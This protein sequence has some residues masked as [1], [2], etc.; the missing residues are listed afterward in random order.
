[1]SSSA[2]YRTYTASR[3]RLPWRSPA[4]ET[5]T[6]SW[7]TDSRRSAP[8]SPAAGS[9]RQ[10]TAEIYYALVIRRTVLHDLSVLAIHRT[11]QINSRPTDMLTYLTTYPPHSL[12]LSL[13][14][15]NEPSMSRWHIC[16]RTTTI[17]PASAITIITPTSAQTDTTH[18][19]SS[20]PKL[21]SH[22]PA[23]WSRS[24]QCS[25]RHTSQTGCD[26]TASTQ[27]CA[28]RRRAA[29]TRS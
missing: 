3:C 5:G 24:W 18:P 19:T 28:R 10:I 1:M 25:P 7:R 4:A 22:W 26:G 29:Q 11:M 21:P 6:S 20:F 8:V 13:S 9:A 27:C 12:S 23:A 14:L 2:S 17:S 16:Q 15:Y